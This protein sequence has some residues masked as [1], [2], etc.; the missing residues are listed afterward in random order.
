MDLAQEK[1]DLIAK[2][3]KNDKK[4]SNNEDLYEDFFNETCRRS[5]G[6]IN[7]ISSD[8]TLEAYLKK[9]ATTSILNVLKDSGR[10]RRTKS[11]FQSTNNI[12]LESA[13][14]SNNYAEIKISY[15][16][17]SVEESPEEIIVRKETLKQVATTVLA[18]D[19]NEPE[20]QYLQIYK[21]RYDKGMTQKEISEELGLSQSEISKRLFKLM[22]K[23]KQ[24]FR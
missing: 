17:F 22:T 11:S 7:V 9:V 16:N 3:I 4:F 15:E 10:L 19:N 18:I 13:N 14:V 24:S 23:V 21:L 6:I 1:L 2:V 12:P 8:V 5:L 20:K